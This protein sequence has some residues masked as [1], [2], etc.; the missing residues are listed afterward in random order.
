MCWCCVDFTAHL[1]V[2][3][4]MVCIKITAMKEKNLHHKQKVH[5]EKFRCVRQWQN[6][7]G[8]T[9]VLS[10]FL[11]HLYTWRGLYFT[12]ILWITTY[13]TLKNVTEGFILVSSALR[14]IPPKTK[15]P[16]YILQETVTHSIT[17][18]CY[19]L[20]SLWSSSMWQRHCTP[21]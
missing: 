10:W 2:L 14:C 19:M 5:S 9:K 3:F 1:L 8:E 21:P 12:I 16:F 13:K 4:F 18:G 15:K 6:V 17:E 7:E 20:C 11:Q